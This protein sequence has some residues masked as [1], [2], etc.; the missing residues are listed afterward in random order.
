M[1]PI[2]L[3]SCAMAATAAEARFRIDAPIRGRQGARVIALDE[4]ANTLVRRVARLDWNAA[5]FFM[6]ESRVPPVDGN[7]SAAVSLSGLDG[8]A[9]GL[10]DELAQADVVV[11]IATADGFEHARWAAAQ[12]IGNACAARGIMTAGL[13]LGGRTASGPAL[14]AL[15][16]YVRVL[17][18]TADEDDVSEVL[19]A[20]RA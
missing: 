12:A 19:T 14:S 13:I 4:A 10:A 5:R 11:M 3:N 16:P 18:V 8:V 6:V 2:L 1:R 20:L 17:M 15:R 9:A 7:G